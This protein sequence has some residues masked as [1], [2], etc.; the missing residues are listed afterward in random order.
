[1]VISRNSAEAVQAWLARYG[2]ADQIRHV[3]AG[4]YPPGHAQSYGHLIENALQAQRAAPAECVLI[5]ASAPVVEAAR[6]AGIRSIGYATTPAVRERLSAAGADCLV[7]SLA[8]LTLR[9]RAR[10]L[11]G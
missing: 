6:S 4:S 11:P 3:A 8:D 9:L 2:L 10:P 5:T 1:V 7:P